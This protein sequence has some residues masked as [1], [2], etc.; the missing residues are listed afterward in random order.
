M[1]RFVRWRGRSTGIVRLWMDGGRGRQG[2][3]GG[4]LGGVGGAWVTNTRR[5]VRWT[6]K[7]PQY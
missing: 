4:E 3:G 2:G 6:R 1:V 7:E 5:A